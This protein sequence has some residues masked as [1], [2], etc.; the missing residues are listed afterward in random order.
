MAIEVGVDALSSV[1]D[2]RAYAA[3]RL[4]SGVVPPLSTDVDTEAANEALL[5][6]AL[7]QAGR[8]MRTYDWEGYP[9]DREQ[10]LCYPRRAVPDP[11]AEGRG[12]GFGGRTSTWIPP[13][14]IPVDV[15]R[16]EM[17][18]SIQLLEIAEAGGDEGA[19]A[20]E[21]LSALAGLKSVKVGLIQVVKAD[22]PSLASK[23]A[24]ISP[25]NAAVMELLAPYLRG[26][27]A[28]LELEY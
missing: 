2:L 20:S 11:Y 16:G 13:D 10:A 28:T 14:E 24:A 21:I 27:A 1:A 26:T 18:R 25:P 6:A 22:Q 15:K 3:V 23:S 5:G 7:M 8:E 12:I 9:V 4:Q 17:E 19:G